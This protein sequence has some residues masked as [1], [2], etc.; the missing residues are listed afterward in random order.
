MTLGYNYGVGY[1][2]DIIDICICEEL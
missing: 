2:M 1:L